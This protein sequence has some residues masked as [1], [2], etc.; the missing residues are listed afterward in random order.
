MTEREL[1]LTAIAHILTGIC[2]STCCHR[3]GGYGGPLAHP[4]CDCRST[5][6]EV[7]TYLENNVLRPENEKSPANLRG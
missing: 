4:N 1:H 5:A 2:A 7:L 3:T 6:N